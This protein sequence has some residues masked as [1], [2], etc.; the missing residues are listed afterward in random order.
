MAVGRQDTDRIYDEYILP[1]LRASGIHAIF[2]GRLEHNDDIDKRIIREIEAC[3]FAIADLTYARPSVYFE[4]GFAQ[5]KVPVI[6][7]CR[8]DHFR[9]QPKDEHGNLRVH[10]DLLMRNIISWTDHRDKSFARKL[11]KRIKIVIEPMIRARQAIARSQSDELQFQGLPLS[12]RLQIVAEKFRVAVK[13]CGYSSLVAPDEYS[14]WVGR[15][16]R[17]GT[18]DLCQIIVQ[19]NFTQR[20]IKDLASSMGDLLRTRFEKRNQYGDYLWQQRWPGLKPPKPSETKDV[21][22]V[23]AKLVLCSLQ[24]IPRQRVTAALMYSTPSA[25]GNL[26]R[27]R[28]ELHRYQLALPLL[29]SAYIADP[30][31]SVTDASERSRNLSTL[32]KATNEG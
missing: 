1:T 2:M 19:P 17:S 24:R 31:L 26:F 22:N 11:G 32:I 6:Y 8:E 10:F 25:N 7:T 30:I 23:V 12:S 4:A 20:N 27:W 18:L 9:P 5:R 16:L 15:I 14:P 21:K 28:S 3:D 29:Y 13:R